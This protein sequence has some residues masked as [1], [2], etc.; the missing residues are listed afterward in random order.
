[1]SF[2]EGSSRQIDDVSQA[3]TGA[4]KIPA[5]STMQ[6]PCL[7]SI[8]RGL[9]FVYCFSLPFKYLLFVERIGFIIL[10]CLVV[11]WCLLRKRYPAI[12]SQIALPVIAFIGWIGITIPWA[13]FPWYSLGELGKVVHDIF[14]LT[15]VIVFFREPSDLRRLLQAMMVSLVAMSMLGVGEF[16]FSPPGSGSVWSTS[17]RAGSAMGGN[18]WLSSYLVILIPIAGCLAFYTQ[19]LMARILYGSAAVLGLACMFLSCSSAGILAV[20]AQGFMAG[21]VL[22]QRRVIVTMVVLTVCLLGG[23]LTYKY[24]LDQQITNEEASI[25]PRLR[26]EYQRRGGTVQEY[27]LRARLNIL[28]FGLRELGAHPLVGAGF[29]KNT[30]DWVYREKTKQL[31]D[32]VSHPMPGGLHN[33]FLDFALGIGLPGLAIF[34]WLLIAITRMAVSTCRVATCPLSQA[35]ALAVSTIVIGTAVRD[36]FDHM[37]AGNIAIL[38]WVAVA[39][40]CVVAQWLQEPGQREEA[41]SQ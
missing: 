4:T 39:A 28:A 3:G 5:W 10:V 26:G 23:A 22:R 13:S 12:P 17:F 25:E 7:D 14:V 19:Q 40:C 35:V 15:T 33:T 2:L 34:I 11:L 20:I 41:D 9:F 24:S 31:H 32:E 36:F 8:I 6:L 21:W 1:M 29:G 27:N 30:F 18:M 37:F 38:F 16:I